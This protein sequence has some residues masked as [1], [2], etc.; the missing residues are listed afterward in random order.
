ML[1]GTCAHDFIWLVRIPL[2]FGILL[3][4]CRI[5]DPA[6]QGKYKNLTLQSVL[7]ASAQARSVDVVL[8]EVVTGLAGVRDVALARIWLVGPGDS[9]STCRM[10]SECRDRHPRTPRT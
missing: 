2:L 5:T 9:C 10:A 6:T 4:I 7:L 1:N 8:K 3:A